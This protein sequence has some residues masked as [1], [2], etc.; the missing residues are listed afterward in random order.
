MFTGTETSSGK[1]II[2]HLTNDSEQM[3]EFMIHNRSG[4]DVIYRF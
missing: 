1:I 2:T 4:C 3:N